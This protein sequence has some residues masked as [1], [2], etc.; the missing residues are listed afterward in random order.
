MDAGIADE[1]G[2]DMT[3]ISTSSGKRLSRKM[4]GADDNCDSTRPGMAPAEDSACC[5][6]E[7]KTDWLLLI[8][9]SIVALGYAAHLAIAQGVLPDTIWQ[10]SQ[11]IF[12]FLNIMW[13][14]LVLGIVFVGILSRVPRE[15]VMGVLGRKDGLG[16]I[17]RATGAGLLLDLC[18]H[19]ILLVGMKLYERGAS[20]G[21]TMA[22]LIASP[23]NSI[24][25]T[26]ILVA[27]VGIK[28]TL[29]FIAL[30][31]VIAIVSGMIFEKL[32]AG[33]TLPGNPHRAA[34]GKPVEFWK[35]LK[36]QVN[37]IQWSPSL[38]RNILVEG[39]AE[40]RMILR[41]VFLG[42]V[43]AGLIR[44]S[45]S[46]DTFSTYFGPTLFGLAM[47]LIATTIIEVCSEGSS[48]IAAD[49]LTRAGAPG[50][51]FTFLMAGAATDYTEIMG[52]K[53]RT[54]SWKIALFL[55]LVTVPQVLLLGYILNVM[56]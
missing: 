12:E 21:Q 52:L 43:L 18:S 13:W 53:E 32:V 16:G 44:V 48:P 34:V 38:I 23:W 17:L 40:S 51:A 41:W 36:A 29:T 47:T 19:G 35:E 20:L 55:P 54:G 8:C 30:S 4:A 46:S 28:W 37:G 56:G 3:E 27:L 25:L 39:F 49:L 14:G 7:R 50:N 2:Q 45:M 26:I 15:L 33:G 10:F 9:G 6:S 11:A 5:P 22:F 31:G 1:T 24:S 42:I